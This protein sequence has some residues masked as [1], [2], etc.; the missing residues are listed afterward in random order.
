VSVSDPRVDPRAAE[1]VRAR[2]DAGATLKSAVL[3]YAALRRGA[4]VDRWSEDVVLVDAGSGPIPFSG[5]NG[6]SCSVVGRTICDRK[7]LTHACLQRAG[8]AVA[9]GR[10]FAIDRESAAR[11]YAREAGAPLVVKPNAAARGRGVTVGIFDLDTFR[12]AW[13]R[14]VKA[15]ARRLEGCVIVERHVTGDDYRC[16]VVDDRM[17]SATRRVRAHVVGNDRDDVATL[18]AAKN[19]QRA[20]NPYLRRYPIPTELALLDALREA[21]HGLDHVPPAGAHVTLRYTSNLAT[22]GDSVDVTDS[23]HPSFGEVAVAALRAIPGMHYGG[24]DLLAHDVSLPASPE[25]H[26]VSEIEYAPG[27][28]PYFPV[29]GNPRDVAGAVLGFYLDGRGAALV[30][31]DGVPRQGAG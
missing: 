10:S 27:P 1:F 12:E 11:R 28:G 3:E 4:R 6:P 15:I 16:F 2:E 9:A 22:G 31:A 8:V 29:V 20:L 25:N 18:I 21:G 26:V 24:V 13:G 5:M 30:G 23:M 19:R 14:A 17:I 7:E